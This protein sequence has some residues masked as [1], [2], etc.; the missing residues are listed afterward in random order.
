MSGTVL[1]WEIAAVNKKDTN[2]GLMEFAV[3]EELQHLVN[4]G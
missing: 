4:K 1:G 3:I 2:L